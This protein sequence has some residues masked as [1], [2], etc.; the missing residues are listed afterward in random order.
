MSLHSADQHLIC[1]TSFMMQNCS[2]TAF[3][4]GLSSWHWWSG[5]VISAG[6]LMRVCRH[7]DSDEIA[8]TGIS[9]LIL[10]ASVP[11]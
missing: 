2:L 10:P 3:Y 6:L 9:L 7:R 1:Q 8:P 11:S 5:E 4:V